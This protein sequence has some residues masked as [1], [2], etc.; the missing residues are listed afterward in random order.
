MFAIA[1][2][3]DIIFDFD[4]DNLI[5]FWMEGA[6]PDPVL[7]ID[8]SDVYGIL[9]KR[10]DI[11]TKVFELLINQYILFFY[12]GSNKYGI[13]EPILKANNHCCFNPYPML[14]A[15]SSQISW[16]RG[17]PLNSVLS[18]TTT[19]GIPFIFLLLKLF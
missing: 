10:S 9:G 19:L 7:D 5:K 15:P 13:I 18:T 4:D 16:P 12:I 6:S 1:N 14:G 17:L 11:V 2:G 3:A 8:N